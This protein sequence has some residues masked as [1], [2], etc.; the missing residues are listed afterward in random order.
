MY[1]R[2]CLVTLAAPGRAITFQYKAPAGTVLLRADSYIVDLARNT[3]LLSKPQCIA[4]QGGVIASARYLELSNFDWKKGSNQTIDVTVAG[5]DARLV[6]Y[7]SG[8]FQIDDLL[9]PRTKSK[10]TT[11]FTVTLEDTHLLLDDQVGRPWKQAATAQSVKVSGVG[12][13]WVASGAVQLQN[14]GPV[15][16]VVSHS[17]DEG[18]KISGVTPGAT[19]ADLLRHVL[20]LPQIAKYE[21]VRKLNFQQVAVNGPFQINIPASG[22]FQVDAWAHLSAREVSYD[23]YHLATLEFTGRV[24]NKGVEGQANVVEDQNR[25][26]FAGAAVWG[27]G[28][29]LAGNL[30]V[31]APSEQ[32]LPAFVRAKL[33]A[34]VHFSQAR[35]AGWVDQAPGKPILARGLLTAATIKDADNPPVTQAEATVQ[36]TPTLSQIRISRATVAGTRPTGAFQIDTK[37]GTL[38]GY[39]SA[40]GLRPDLLPAAYHVRGLS[41]QVDAQVTLGGSVHTPAARFS[42]TGTASYR[43]GKLAFR[44]EQVDLVGRVQKGEVLVERGVAEGSEGTLSVTGTTTGPKQVAMHVEARNFSAGHFYPGVEGLLSARADLSGSLSSFR[45]LGRAEGADLTYDKYSVPAASVDFSGNR[46][47]LFLDRISAVS[48]TAS[49]LGSGM[50]GFNSKAISGRLQA[51]GIS[52]TDYVGD[53]YA[54]IV[55][56]PDIQ[57]GGTLTDPQVTAR[58]T[59]N[60]LV[61]SDME[62]EAAEGLLRYGGQKLSLDHATANLANGSVSASGNYDLRQKTGE[63]DFASTP[64]ALDLLGPALGETV[65]VGGTTTVTAGHLAYVDGNLSGKASGAVNQISVNGTAAGDGN[66]SADAAGRQI[67]GS[68]SIGQLMPEL[69]V[70][71]ADA[72]YDLDAKTLSGT[73]DAQKVR[74][75]DILAAGARYMPASLADSPESLTAFVGDLTGGANLSGPVDHL[76]L[77]VPTFEIDSLAYSGQPFGTVTAE[78]V[79]RTNGTWTVPAMKV[80]GPAGTLSLAGTAAEKG[81][82]QITAQGRGL[83]L[84]AFA[85]FAPSLTGNPGAADFDL[86]GSGPIDRPSLTGTGQVHDIASAPESIAKVTTQDSNLNV[87]FTKL[88]LDDSH[89]EVGGTYTFGGFGGNFTA[90]TPFAYRMKLSDTKLSGEVTLDQRSILDVPIIAAYLDPTKSSGS[91]SGKLTLGGSLADPSASGGITMTAPHIGVSFGSNSYVKRLDDG[92]KNVNVAVNVTPQRMADFTASAEED[93]GGT[94]NATASVSFAANTDPSRQTS[95]TDSPVTGSIK[96]DKYTFRQSAPG[97]YVSGQLSGETGISGSLSRPVFGTRE[98]AGAFTLAN[99]DTAIPTL[100]SSTASTSVPT[101]DPNF[102][103]GVK[104][105]NP[106]HIRSSTADFMLNG[107]GSFRGSLS[108]PRADADL[109]VQSGSIRLPG[110]TLKLSQGGSVT[111]SYRKPFGDAPNTTL[112]VDLEGTTAIT[113]VRYGTNAQHYDVVVDITGDMLNQNALQMSA[114]SDPPDLNSDDVMALLGEKSLFES[115]GSNPG[116]L[117]DTERQVTNAVAGFALPNLLDPVTSSVAKEL[118]LDYVSLDY[119]QL[120]M[121]TISAAR[122]LNSDFTMQLRQQIGPA[123]P[124]TKPIT[125]LRLTYS[126]RRVSAALRRFSIGVGYDQDNPWKVML[127]YGSRFGPSS[128]NGTGKK[129]VISPVGGTPR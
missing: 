23:Q 115:I 71:E 104:L 107:G 88:A 114:Y 100:P 89:A 97:G 125:D 24:G 55:D 82:M 66:W 42:A 31:M 44:N 63:L 79:T 40:N 84:A 5:L 38:T 110:G 74:I 43:E 46:D 80:T 118:G 60:N 65:Q 27:H 29:G 70:L 47:L 117:N 77:T 10:S 113:T 56:L 78:N 108:D 1:V 49:L 83:K 116:G 51:A 90:S 87:N 34:G 98:K 16:A 26:T 61:A 28:L 94:L 8:R 48:S 69:R 91:I 73:V 128:G 33:P 102:N 119:S 30:S 58:V 72:T 64:L 2:L 81:A 92:L 50:Y 75:Q 129:T 39:A 120:D 14:V 25:G 36:V 12:S 21:E 57:L 111:F 106:A 45:Y 53:N 95:F 76:N 103:I 101:I 3:V 96:F 86:K 20:S 4:P 99:V 68:I 52:L 85:P 18:L 11:A 13:D 37:L 127:Q 19:A 109:M 54:G 15:R 124:G 105:S 6:R 126:P 59:A 62:I 122:S 123:Y 22:P 9:P 121:T 112:D 17:P 93:R 35:F 32:T 7:A 41:G 67:H